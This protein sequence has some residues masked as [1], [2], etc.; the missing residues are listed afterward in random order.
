MKTHLVIGDPHAHPD[1]SN[2]R[3]DW[4]GRLILDLKPDVVVNMGDTADMASMSAYDK[5]KASFHGRNY[6]RDIEAH[7]NFQDRMW[8]PIRK[9][10]R[11]L[12]YR[13][14]LEGNH[15]N[16]IKTALQYSP[17]LE[18]DRFGVSFKNLA[19]DYYY[20]TVVEYEAKTPG[21]INIDGV[22]YCHFAVSGISGRALSSIH[23]GYDLTT[24]RH[25][26]TTVGHSH[27]LDYH[28]SKDSTGRAKMGLVAGVYQDYRS[29]WAGD[30]N[31]FWSPG[32]AICRNVYNG[33]YD[34][35]W[36]GI[37]TIKREYS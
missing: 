29:P 20:D 10:K 17:E 34:L 19:L 24:K 26:S 1:F 21:V 12:P 4:L 33:V 6:E 3:A 32:L 27:L 31:S 5:G 11:K 14:V 25:V 36:V 23:H 35:Q 7:L 18:G 8:A 13:V 16:R 9:A 30:I 22:D 37:D 2:D 28:I 15:E